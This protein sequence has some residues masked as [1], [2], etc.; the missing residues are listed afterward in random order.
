MKNPQKT[1]GPLQSFTCPR[2]N[3]VSVSRAEQLKSYWHAPNA[4]N[5]APVWFTRQS[6]ICLHSKDSAVC[7]SCGN[8]P[9]WVQLSGQA[10][11]G[12]D[13]PLLNPSYDSWC[14]QFQVDRT[15]CSP[16]MM[17]LPYRPTRILIRSM[18]GWTGLVIRSHGDLVRKQSCAQGWEFDG[19]WTIG[20]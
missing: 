8:N 1:W 9:G 19:C 2:I 11:N 4:S 13:I 5:A 15:T 6:V 20:V 17:S 10:K 7:T 18:Q 3:F 16:I 12:K 14:C